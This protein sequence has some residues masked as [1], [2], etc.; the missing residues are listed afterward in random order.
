MHS[1]LCG[2]STHITERKRAEQATSIA[3]READ[4]ANLAKSDFLSRMSHDLRT[5]LNAIM[6]FAQV[7]ELDPLLPAQTDSVR[8]IMRGGQHL[9]NLINEVL[10]IARIEAGHLTL[11]PEPVQIS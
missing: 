5:P 8:Q 3:R 6:G 7:L 4:R 10:D 2:I 9:L 1:A 11:S